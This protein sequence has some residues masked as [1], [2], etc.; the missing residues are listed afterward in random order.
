MATWRPASDRADGVDTYPLMAAAR[1][2]LDELLD[3]IAS[4]S[5]A[6]MRR[7][8]PTRSSTPQVEAVNPAYETLGEPR[9]SDD[10]SVPLATSRRDPTR[11]SAPSLAIGKPPAPGESD[12]RES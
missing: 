4:S 5:R 11:R 12:A 9:H 1:E 10:D 6:A 3:A 8:S 2:A 7:P